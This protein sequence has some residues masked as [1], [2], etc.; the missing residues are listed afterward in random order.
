[1]QKLIKQIG[2]FLGKLKSN[3]NNNCVP[4]L[5]WDKICRATCEDG[6][7]IQKTLDVNIVFLAK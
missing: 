5:A 3:C 2:I 6:P 4:T 7:G 1:M